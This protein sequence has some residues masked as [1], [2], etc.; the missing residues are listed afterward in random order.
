M[1]RPISQLLPP[2]LHHAGASPQFGN[3]SQSSYPLSGGHLNP[4][5]NL[6]SLLQLPMKGDQQRSKDTEMKGENISIN[7][8]DFNFHST[9]LPSF[10]YLVW[11]VSIDPTL[12][13][14]S[15]LVLFITAAYRKW[16]S[17][18]WFQ[19]VTIIKSNF[20]ICNQKRQAVQQWVEFGQKYHMTAVRSLEALS[21]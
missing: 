16:L 11:S 12:V 7:S 3:S 21:H 5:A 13:S 19:I 18:P 1:S 14:T 2:D 6:K 20:A 4:A 9:L 15:L 10:W 8:G 17:C